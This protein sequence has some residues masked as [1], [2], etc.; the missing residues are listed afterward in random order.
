MRDGEIL[1]EILKDRKFDELE[2]STEM[3][4]IKSDDIDTMI[5]NCISRRFIIP[6][7]NW[8][9]NQRNVKS[10]ENVEIIAA[11]IDIIT[12]NINQISLYF[13]FIKAFQTNSN[14][15]IKINNQKDAL[16]SFC[17]F[18]I[19]YSTYDEK[20]KTLNNDLVLSQCNLKDEYMNKIMLDFRTKKNIKI[21][22]LISILRKDFNLKPNY[23]NNILGLSQRT[24]N[25]Q[26]SL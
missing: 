20:T 13:G 7:D 1:M 5:P 15:G 3:A 17:A 9:T 23:K 8:I 12:S 26:S 25:K 19:V 21:D 2:H 4:V 10:F 22:D 16:W 6:V 18:Q 14:T 11:Q 24:I